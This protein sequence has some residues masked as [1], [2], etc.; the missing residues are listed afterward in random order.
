MGGLFLLQ[1]TPRVNSSHFPDGTPG[2]D[3]MCPLP[4]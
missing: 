1:I 2:N 4:D 3:A